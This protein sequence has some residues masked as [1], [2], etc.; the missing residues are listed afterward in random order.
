MASA[1]VVPQEAR[2]KSPPPGAQP[3]P[4]NPNETREAYQHRVNVLVEDIKTALHSKRAP[5]LMY[6]MLRAR[7]LFELVSDYSATAQRDAFRGLATPFNVQKMLTDSVF[8][9]VRLYFLAQYKQVIK[10]PA[11]SNWVNFWSDLQRVAAEVSSFLQHAELHHQTYSTPFNYRE[12][13]YSIAHETM[14]SVDPNYIKGLQMVMFECID[15]Q[16]LSPKDE[17][18]LNQARAC[19]DLDMALSPPNQREAAYTHLET[20]YLTDLKLRV[21]RLK[22]TGNTQD[23][24]KK[25]DDIISEETRRCETVFPKPE[26]A[27][28]AKRFIQESLVTERASEIVNDRAFGVASAISY[29]KFN[30]ALLRQ[31][32][33]VLEFDKICIRTMQAAVGTSVGEAVAP[34]LAKGKVMDIYGL[35]SIRAAFTDLIRVSIPREHQLDFYCA[36]QDGTASVTPKDGSFEEGLVDCIDRLIRGKPPTQAT[37]E[38]EPT[39][40]DTALSSESVG[41][42]FDEDPKEQSK[43]ASI[44][45]HLNAPSAAPGTEVVTRSKTLRKELLNALDAL[46][47]V[48]SMELFLEHYKW[49]LSKRLLFDRHPRPRVEAFVANEL[50]KR[51]GQLCSWHIT[52]MLREATSTFSL[53]NASVWPGGWAHRPKD[54]TAPGFSGLAK[55]IGDAFTEFLSKDRRR[56]KTDAVD[57]WV[58]P[59]LSVVELDLN[60]KSSPHSL[61]LLCSAI[62]AQLVI[63]ISETGAKGQTQQE[64]HRTS[65][66]S[67]PSIGLAMVALVQ[68]KVILNP[69]ES[70]ALYFFNNDFM[71]DRKAPLKLALPLVR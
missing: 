43:K 2:K 61:R 17:S 5:N 7:S 44:T 55:P 4:V 32:F 66:F 65:G 8:E 33:N 11:P 70:P 54:P 19:F 40:M 68:S 46:S 6:R 3:L 29:P 41:S 35:L 27:K 38:P 45:A 13:V 12:K 37:A 60:F 1:A 28:K 57:T 9:E 31:L 21:K 53:M 26:S 69:T 30:P 67:L 48:T 22:V 42:D 10:G 39:E 56:I 18:H 16:R 20:A 63:A 24:L 47:L 23:Y 50:G 25:V 49:R 15:R 52:L 36:V 59:A 14:A 71:K 62:Q 64:L 51:K 34:L 58:D